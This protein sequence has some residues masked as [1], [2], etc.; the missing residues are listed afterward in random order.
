[1]ARYFPKVGRVP[2][3]GIVTGVG[4]LE[5]EEEPGP[6]LLPLPQTQFPQPRPLLLDSQFQSFQAFYS[7]HVRTDMYYRSFK[8]SASQAKKSIQITWELIK[9]ADL[10]S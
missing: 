3:P 4:G 9:N 2:N 7:A 5:T 8:A 10:N 1:M 6:T